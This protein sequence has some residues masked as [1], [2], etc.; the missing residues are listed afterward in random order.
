VLKRAIRL[1]LRSALVLLALGTCVFTPSHQ[2]P[3]AAKSIVTIPADV[4]SYGLIFVRTRINNSQPLSFALDSG[5]SFPVVIDSRRARDLGLK[6]QGNLTLEGGAG[7]GTFEVAM[8]SGVSVSFGGLEL[9]GQTAA[10][11]ALGSLEAIAGRPLDGLIGRDLFTRYVVEIDYLGKKISL[12]APQTYTYSGTGE[13]IPIALRGDYL[14]VPAKIG[15][16]GRPPL[17]G[18]FLVDTGGGFVTAILNAPFARSRGVPAPTQGAVLD[19]SL[20][21]LGGQISLHVCRA[22]SFA[23]GKLA[24]REPVIYVSQDRGGALAT[25]DFDGVIGGEIL[26]RFKVIFDYSRRRLILEPNIHYPEPVEY[27]MSGVRLRA[28]GS[29]FRSFTLSQVLENSPAAHAGLREG[30]LLYTIDGAPASSFSLDEIYQ[31]LKQPGRE[32][33]LSIRRGSETLSVTI[34]L[35]RLI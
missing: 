12:Y 23:L 2:V 24:I 20:S 28:G 30:D 15:L 7:A 33:K 9:S 16:P 29:D 26:R 8:T 3:S 34:K 1:H 27:D 22:T 17:E 35:K 31:M 19:S 4:T 32:Y 10:V 21:G 11:F 5:A 25:A 6:L 13:S 18:Q 14:F